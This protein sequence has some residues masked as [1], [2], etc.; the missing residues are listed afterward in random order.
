VPRKSNHDWCAIVRSV[1][2][3]TQ[4][5]KCRPDSTIVAKLKYRPDGI[6]LKKFVVPARR[7]CSCKVQS[8]SAVQTVVQF[9]IYGTAQ[10]APYLDRLRQLKLPTLKHRLLRG[11]MFEIFKIIHNYYDTGA[12]VKSNFDPVGSRG[13]T[14]GN[15]FKFRKDVSIWY[16]YSFCYRVVDVG[17]SLLDYMVEADSVNSFKSRLDK[18]WDNQE[19]VFNLNSELIGTGGL[20]V[21]M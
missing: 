13:P 7:H 2:V 5:L 18:Y 10:T 11:N 3:K 14:R 19:F 12:S 8:C 20:P 9:Y 1:I 16:K 4:W 6:S 21:C 15:K 17:K